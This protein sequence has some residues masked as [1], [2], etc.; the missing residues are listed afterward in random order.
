VKAGYS[1][2]DQSQSIIAGQRTMS[3]IIQFASPAGLVFEPA[4]KKSPFP[5]R[6]PKPIRLNLNSEPEQR[7]WKLSAQAVSTKFAMI[8]LFF[9]VLFLVAALAGVTSCFADL[10]HL[11]ESDAIGHVA[12]KV[13]SGAL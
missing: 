5:S 12:A 6:E 4:E 11:L 10:S 13:V 3:A 2:K 8:E 7:L 1:A 9:L